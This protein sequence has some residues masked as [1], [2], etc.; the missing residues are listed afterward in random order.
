MLLYGVMYLF[1]LPTMYLI[2]IIYAVA[3]LHDQSWGTR[4]NAD[5]GQVK[6][7]L[8]NWK[9][10]QRFLPVCFQCCITDELESDAAQ[11]KTVTDTDANVV[12]KLSQTENNSNEHIIAV[13]SQSKQRELSNEKDE[14]EI[15]L[16]KTQKGKEVVSDDITSVTVEKPGTSESNQINVNTNIADA[17][18]IPSEGSLLL[19]DFVYMDRYNNDE[20]LLQFMSMALKQSVIASPPPTTPKDKK[21]LDDEKLKSIENLTSLRNFASVLLLVATAIW[22]TLVVSVQLHTEL[23]FW[24]SGNCTNAGDNSKVCATNSV[25]FVFLLLF[26][27]MQLG[28]WNFSYQLDY[29]HFF[30]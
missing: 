19:Q 12:N 21:K 4:E 13:A 10:L 1:L 7:D 27:L 3:N 11:T 17:I 8:F 20:V 2:L 23:Q 24:N 29:R 26:G 5:D 22:L 28:K 14:E 25:G 30:S 6:S 15:Q 16:L 9:R 18:S